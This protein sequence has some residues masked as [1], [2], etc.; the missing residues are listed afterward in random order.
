MTAETLRV[1][2]TLNVEI[3]EDR[4]GTVTMNRPAA[5]NAMNTRMMEELRACFMDFYVNPDAAACL[6]LT[7]AGAGFFAGAD[8]KERKGMPDAV[9]RRQPAIVEQMVRAL[10]DCPVPV[11]AA[12]NGA[13]IGGG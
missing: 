9:W 11:I 4:V 2:E 5:R 13:D 6:I 7:G 12:V 8:L 10:M 3:G 1:Y